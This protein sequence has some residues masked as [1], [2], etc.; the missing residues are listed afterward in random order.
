MRD[1]RI[2]GEPVVFPIFQMAPNPTGLQQMTDW[3]GVVRP[4]CFEGTEGPTTWENLFP[5]DMTEGGRKLSGNELLVEVAGRSCYHSFGQKAGRKSNSE[6]IA[7]TQEGTSPH[8]SILY[9]TR[10]VL[11][12]A[13]VS[14]R[15][16]HELIR[17]Y[18][19]C[20]GS[21]DGSPSQ[22]STRYTESPG[23]YVPSP[24]ILRDPESLAEY[25]SEVQRSYN[26]YNAYIL[27]KRQEYVSRKGKEP[28]G[29]ARKRIYE[30]ASSLLH[31]STATSFV[32]SGNC[33]AIS[34]LIY[35]RS[36]ANVDEEFQRLS[37]KMWEVV[38]SQDPN[39]YQK[40]GSN[41]PKY[42]PVSLF[43]L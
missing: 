28:K 30:A 39:L 37:V 5:H 26:A 41:P 20:G 22:E 27:K 15:L 23:L 36:A 3:L 8:K 29:I 31:H 10:T 14:R 32:W 38:S 12:I 34:K 11:F 40:L 9:H 6:Y 43:S 7:H 19:G 1:V 16:S 17:H 21:E 4:E 42:E 35:E 2:I 24:Q 33:E 25:T 13:G 18:V